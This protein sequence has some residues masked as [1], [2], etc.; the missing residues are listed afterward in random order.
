VLRVWDLTTGKQLHA[1]EGHTGSVFG[2]ALSADGSHAASA[3]DDR[4]LR[5]WDLTT[6]E[7]LHVSLLPSGEYATLAC[8]RTPD[9][10]SVHPPGAADREVRAQRPNRVLACSAGAWRWLGWIAPAPGSGELTRYPAEI[11]GPL[12]VAG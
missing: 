5:V 10:T 1:L 8:D 2:V 7:Q 12:P 6:G 11:F 9:G 3:G 4:V